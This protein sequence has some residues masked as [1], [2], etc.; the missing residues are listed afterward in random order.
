MKGKLTS[1]ILSLCLLLR[2]ASSSIYLEV[3]NLLKSRAHTFHP[4]ADHFHTAVQDYESHVRSSSVHSA[5]VVH[6]F[7]VQL[8]PTCDHLCHEAVAQEVGG[9][10]GR[11]EILSENYAIVSSSRLSLETFSSQHPEMVRD[12][13]VMLPEMKVHRDIRH[14]A[15]DTANVACGKKQISGI[16]LAFHSLASED[17][18]RVIAFLRAFEHRHKGKVRLGQIDDPIPEGE[19]LYF[20]LDVDN[21]G[22]MAELAMEI[23]RRPEVV[24]IEHKKAMVTFN[25]WS[26]GLCDVGNTLY[27]PLNNNNFTG[28]GEVV[29]IADTGLDMFNCY[30]YDPDHNVSYSTSTDKTKISVNTAH[31]KVIQYVAYADNKENAE[32]HGTH[33]SGSVAGLAYENY[34]D[35]QRFNGMSFNAKIAFFDIGKNNT[36][37]RTVSTPDNI[38]THML[39]VMYAAGARIFSNSWGSE[40][41]NSYD[42]QAQQ[43]DQFMFD[44]PDA[45]VLFAAGNNGT[46]PSATNEVSS[47]STAK[48]CLT[49]GAASND[50]ESWQAVTSGTVSD[51]A[52]IDGVAYFSSPGPTADNRLKPDVLA[53]GFY[54]F[55]A[56]G[57]G[58]ATEYFCAIDG[59]SGTSMATPTA[60]GFA[61]KIRQYFMEGYYPSGVQNASAAFI[62]SGA[63]IKAVMIASAQPMKYF[64]YSASNYAT[65]SG[66]PSIYQGYGRI[67]MSAVLQFGSQATMNPLNLFVVGSKNSSYPHYTQFLGT[68]GVRLYTVT[69]SGAS[70]VRVVLCYTDRSG[71]AASD[72]TG[73]KNRLTLSVTGNDGSSY[74]PYRYGVYP[75]SNVQVIDITSST[76]T[77]YTI[78]I[79]ATSLSA[80]P[81]AF[82]LVAVS[83]S[84]TYLADGESNAVDRSYHYGSDSLSHS[85]TIYVIVFTIVLAAMIVFVCYVRGISQARNATLLNPANYANEST[86]SF[87]VPD[88]DEGQKP[89]LFNRVFGGGRKPGVVRS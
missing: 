85:A 4:S 76:S 2:F 27:T 55:S 51:A 67:E 29:G 52:G 84:T 71:S 7:V 10:Q 40:G 14:F 83:N 32:G 23:A 89:T 18:H 48:N 37:Y 15:T 46:T 63:L 80:S 35:Y 26:K 73:M 34:G 70:T 1:T 3:S 5:S 38:N 87:D 69:T 65:L 61:L 17:A 42:T 79:V 20:S 19:T 6:P 53:P 30:L 45:L 39:Q 47:P 50:H 88:E 54:V 74:T 31:R 82:S 77:V 9:Q 59:K 43:V 12:Y 78:K 21:C 11:Y 41:D 44:Y 22:L 66:Y 36:S 57:T 64:L 75:Y 16:R 28:Y 56:K 62:P 68:G 49:V 81:Q 86:Y 72:T 25:R 60:A 24:Y 33:V 13:M 58:T 8:A